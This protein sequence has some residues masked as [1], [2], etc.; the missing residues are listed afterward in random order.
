MRF[1]ARHERG[2]G[3]KYVCTPWSGALF[4]CPLVPFFV[5]RSFYCQHANT[6]TFTA[7]QLYS[8]HHN[9]IE[10][11]ADGTGKRRRIR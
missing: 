5:M 9:T 11:A 4:V 3:Y 8:L 6:Y 10:S 2:H 7:S 1:V